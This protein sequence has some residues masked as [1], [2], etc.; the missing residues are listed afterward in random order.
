LAAVD[1][2]AFHKRSELWA[3]VRVRCRR[4]KFTFDIS[5]PD[6]FLVSYGPYTML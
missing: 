3:V 4:K 5:S 1:M 6:E 2:C